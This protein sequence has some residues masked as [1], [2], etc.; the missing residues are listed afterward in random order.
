VLLRCF[1]FTKTLSEHVISPY[2]P[3]QGATT[4]A[5]A[6]DPGERIVLVQQA[7]GY[8]RTEERV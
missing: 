5:V 2:T 6:V 4:F 1:D 7:A 8:A 3:E